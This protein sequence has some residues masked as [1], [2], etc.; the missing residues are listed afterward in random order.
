MHLCAEEDCVDC[1][2]CRVSSMHMVEGVDHEDRRPK[3]TPLSGVDR[4]SM[5]VEVVEGSELPLDRH[6]QDGPWSKAETGVCEKK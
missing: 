6:I 5:H 4:G 3:R 2:D 1:E